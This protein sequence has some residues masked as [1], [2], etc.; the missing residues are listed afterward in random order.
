[1]KDKRHI[2]AMLVED[3]PGVL[4][5][6]AGMFAR[7]GFNIDT[8]T[9]GK[10]TKKGIS[11]MVI[12]VYGDDATLEQVEKQV[13]KLIDTI[14]VIEMPEE[15]SVIRELCLIKVAINGQKA[16]EEILRYTKIYKTKIVDITTKSV[17]AELIGEPAKI[18][19]FIELMKQFGV[20]EISRTGVTAVSRG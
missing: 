6:I 20:K 18:D 5:R 19:A 12:T 13:N 10:T 3:Q 17:T 9:V 4:T 14:K 1:M 15:N 11:K 2:I 16:K 8:I 7:R